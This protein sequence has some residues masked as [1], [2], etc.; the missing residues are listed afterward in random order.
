M[1]RLEGRTAIVTGAS[2]G[3]GR[4][5]A[6]AF[7]REGARV[8][9]TGVHDEAAL[10]D[11]EAE[12]T[13]SG[14][15]ALAI[16][17]D[18]TRRAEMNGLAERVLERWGRIDILVNNAGIIRPALLGDIGEDQWDEMMA[19]HLKGTF[20]GTQ[21]VLPA[22]RRRGS[23]KI[24]NVA[25][26][27]AL[28]GSIGV[29]DYAAAKGGIISLTRNAAEELKPDNIQVNCV[30]PVA[31]TRMIDE[32]ASFRSRHLKE[33]AAVLSLAA[34]VAPEMV[35]PAFVFLACEDC[36]FITGQVLAFNRNEFADPPRPAEDHA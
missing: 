20:L 31:D 3:I 21:A 23:G 12:I 8:A 30:S 17:A 32:L 26:P 34:V 16:M 15:E 10:R 11:A 29:A 25:A 4:A 33:G 22:M 18:V 2:R 13:A 9:I 6:S 27:S 35:A 24:I 7:A 1:G 19:V 36:D 14:G 5:V 28:Q